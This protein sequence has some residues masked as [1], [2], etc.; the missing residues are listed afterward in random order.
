MS[1]INF[2]ASVA[3]IPS[4]KFLKNAY[5]VTLAPDAASTFAAARS[6]FLPNNVAANTYL[7]GASGAALKAAKLP[8]TA[9]NGLIEASGIGIDSSSNLTSVGT[10]S[11]GKITS[12]TA[13]IVLGAYTVTA[14]ATGNLLTSATAVAAF[15]TS[16]TSPIIYGGTA[17]GADLTLAATSHGTP[18]GANILFG[19]SGALGSIAETGAWSVNPPTKSSDFVALNVTQSN[20][21]T[22]GNGVWSKLTNTSTDDGTSARFQCGAGNAACLVGLRA[23]YDTTAADSYSALY[24]THGAGGTFRFVSDNYGGNVGTIDAS[25]NWKNVAG[26]SWGTI[27]DGRLKTN[28]RPIENALKTL[29]ALNPVAYDWLDEKMQRS[30]R[31]K[32]NFITQ[33]VEKVKPEWVS[34]GSRETIEVGGKCV[35]VENVQSVA[36][37][38]SFNAYLVAAIKELKGENDQLKARLERVE[39]K[40]LSEA[41]D[42]LDR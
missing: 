31:P 16:V 40:I 3:K 39:L 22:G 17:D 2:Y 41:S 34:T 33:E 24:W 27:S 37:G 26:G 1:D 35:V 6:F 32:E 11:S 29:C 15:A 30:N 8:K 5:D 42:E 10:I 36:F 23:T 9:T 38:A 14:V 19:A 18:S 13:D 20:T 12:S 4:V 21:A 25:A 28:V 7:L